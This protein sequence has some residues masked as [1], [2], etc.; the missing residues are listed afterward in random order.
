MRVRDNEINS[1]DGSLWTKWEPSELLIWYSLSCI[2]GSQVY[3]INI[4]F[5]FTDQT[6]HTANHKIWFGF[7]WRLPEAPKVG[8]KN[9]KNLSGHVWTPLRSRC[10]AWEEIRPRLKIIYQLNFPK[11]YL[12]SPDLIREP[13]ESHLNVVI[14]Q[15]SCMIVPCLGI[16][17]HM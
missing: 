14:L 2:V 12:D 3:L 10:C 8:Q 15:R 9:S 7:I 16:M 6:F 11:I 13:H 17:A 4:L 5:C 1:F